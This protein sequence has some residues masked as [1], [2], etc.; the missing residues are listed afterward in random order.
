MV[1]AAT[2]KTVAVHQSQRNA[3]T[4]AVVELSREQKTVLVLVG[5]DMM[6]IRL[7]VSVQ[8]MGQIGVNATS[9]VQMVLSHLALIVYVLLVS[10]AGMEV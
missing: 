2:R 5:K 3:L 9:P 6:S 4:S 10:H 8:W 7:K 1:P